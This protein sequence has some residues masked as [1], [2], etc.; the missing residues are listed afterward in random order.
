MKFSKILTATML[1]LFM[2]IVFVA[3]YAFADGDVITPQDFFA[4]V[5]AT[6]QKIGGLPMMGKISAVILLI[7]AS[8][9]VSFLNEWIWSKLGA[10]KAAAGL[11]LGLVAGILGLGT[12]QPITGALVFAYVTAG[13]GAVVLHEL[14]D[15]VKAIPGIGSAY[16]MIINLIQS[17]LGGPKKA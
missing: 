17:F 12:D 6:I 8:M 11:V 7:V 4:Q 1:M 14:L 15:M 2:S 16:V 10:Y 5:L 13:G 9:K 3:T